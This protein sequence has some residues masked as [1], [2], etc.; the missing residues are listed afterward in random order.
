[1][2]MNCADYLRHVESSEARAHLETCVACR[3]TERMLRAHGR[4]ELAPP[5]GLAD[6]VMAAIDRPESKR[7]LV[8]E[9]WRFAAA[10]AAVVVVAVS[11]YF[12]YDVAPIVSQIREEV[13]AGVES[14][15]Q[16]PKALEER[17]RIILE[18][19]NES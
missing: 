17:V 1:M 12:A 4:Q 6:A 9:I 5:E 3:Q 16:V 19:G 2:T 18:K 15:K 13:G 10:A 8:R 11:T 7:P 14:V